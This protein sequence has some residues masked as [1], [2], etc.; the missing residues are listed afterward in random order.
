LVVADKKIYALNSALTALRD[1][2][3]DLAPAL[4]NEIVRLRRQI[5]GHYV[6]PLIVGL[7]LQSP[8]GHVA[9]VLLSTPLH[10]Y[11][12]VL[13]GLPCHGI[14]GIISPLERLWPEDHRMA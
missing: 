12:D 5:L 3:N 11:G 4:A 10:K 14:L 13:G 9:D 6:A 7:S 8:R 1:L 2:R